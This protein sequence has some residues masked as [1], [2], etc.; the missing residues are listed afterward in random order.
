[1]NKLFRLFT[2]MG[3]LAL[4]GM[5][6]SVAWAQQCT[7]PHALTAQGPDKITFDPSIAVGTTIWTGTVVVATSHGQCAGG[8]YVINLEG[9]R[10]YQG[11][12]L[13]ASGISGISYRLKFQ[14]SMCAMDW[15]PTK[16]PLYRWGPGISGHTLLIELVKTGPIVSGGKLKGR[17][18][19][20]FVNGADFANYS[21]AGVTT[22]ESIKPTC[23]VATPSVSVALGAVP[24]SQFTGVGSTSDAQGFDIT[25][26]CG[27]G[28][29]A[30]TTG[31]HVTL[32]DQV[33]PGNRTDT[34]SL[35]PQSTAKGV[36]IQVL[37][38]GEPIKYGADSAEAGNE[39]QWLA[40]E[41]ANGVF[42][43][44]LTA[45][46]IQTEEIVSAGTA[47]GRATFTLNYQ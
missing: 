35:T 43:I 5:L 40:G 20:W 47:D 29:A 25:L 26:Q 1:M 42:K 36:G 4:L 12:N 44:P 17:F 23:T 9:T 6:P 3:T 16:C 10:A 7:A 45:H 39:N 28:D 18:A 31:V 34:L 21:W 11:N 13:Y 37:R 46:Y 14:T 24:R 22:V 38:E 27:G 30:L 32:T 15:W 19:R 8:T 33:K 41:A 2:W